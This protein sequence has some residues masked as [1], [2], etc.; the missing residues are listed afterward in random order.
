V[1]VLN[2][3]LLNGDLI[4]N[5]MFWIWVLNIFIELFKYFQMFAIDGQQM[6]W[7][8]QD[9]DRGAIIGL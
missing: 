6:Q 9:F 7:R 5:Q 1:V 8:M 2:Y 3:L 4:E